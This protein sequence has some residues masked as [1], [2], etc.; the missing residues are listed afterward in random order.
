MFRLFWLA[1]FLPLLF[2][3]TPLKAQDTT[4]IAPVYAEWQQTD[5]IREHVQ[6]V[7]PVGLKIPD[8]KVED[9][10]R[11]Q[12]AILRKSPGNEQAAFRLIAL[13]RLYLRDP[14]AKWKPFLDIGYKAHLEWCVVQ[15]Q[16]FP[17]GSSRR[18]RWALAVYDSVSQPDGP[19]ALELGTTDQELH[20]SLIVRKIGADEIKRAKELFQAVIMDPLAADFPKLKEVI[21]GEKALP[22]LKIGRT[23]QEYDELRGRY[24][25]LQ[26]KEIKLRIRD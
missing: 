17:M 8:R 10:M 13:S 5:D 14:D 4:R 26:E 21:W 23:V 15:M 19:S 6:A 9:T 12:M 11:A 3:G 18:L 2:G 22:F 7:W 1:L 20:D 25:S 16:K 24:D